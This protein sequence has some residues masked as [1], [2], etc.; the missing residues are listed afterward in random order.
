MIN[1][2]AYDK[3]KN[4]L[5]FLYFLDRE[6]LETNRIYDTIKLEIVK[7]NIR[8]CMY[9]NLNELYISASFLFESVYAYEIFR[10]YKNLFSCGKF[11]VLMTYDSLDNMILLKQEQYKDNKKVF[12]N[13]FNDFWYVVADGDVIFQHKHDDTTQF[14]EENI[15]ERLKN[16][17]HFKKN[18]IKIPFIMERIANRNRSAITH[19]LLKDVYINHDIDKGFQGI[20]NKTISE[21]YIKSYLNY[22]NLTIPTNLS[23]GIFGYDFLSST[24][25]A[26]DM[27]FWLK[28]SIKMGMNKFIYNSNIDIFYE[29]L[30]STEHRE[31]ILLMYKF[32]SNYYIVDSNKINAHF[33]IIE[34]IPIYNEIKINDIKNAKKRAIDVKEKLLI[35]SHNRKEWYNMGYLNKAKN[36]F[37][38]HG[39]NEDIRHAMF[40]F[41]RSIGLTPLSWEQANRYTGKGSPTTMEII[42]A[43]MKNAN[44]II[45]LLTGDDIVRLHEKLLKPN[46]SED[47]Q[48][49][50]RP[51]VLFEAGMAI[52]KYPKETVL[53]KVG[54]MRNISDIDGINYIYV[55]NSAE[56][57]QN[58][59]SRLKT[60]ECQV[61]D[62][63]TEWIKAGDFSINL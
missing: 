36:V 41:L 53:V 60:I 43:G 19:H 49:Q 62:D 32:L 34:L 57:R 47:F 6:L 11:I 20:I 15:E 45:I 13:Y 28:L 16:K 58:L 29:Y 5:L 54:S 22:F 44:A 7:R 30:Q 12:P 3:F 63:N 1:N 42:D 59:I 46:E 56:T 48:L 40:T 8:L 38:V 33:K 31:L 23:I 17:I 26:S 27:S 39:R 9:S 10:E 24:Y 55:D 50:P 14:I 35:K 2:I 37:V 4:S 51:N 61:E 18:I 21:L 25:P 52:A